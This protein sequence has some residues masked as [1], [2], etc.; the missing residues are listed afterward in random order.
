MNSEWGIPTDM[1]SPPRRPTVVTILA[2]M[3]TVGAVVSLL[4]G[5]VLVFVVFQGQPPTGNAP[6]LLAI[7]FG[8]AAVSV[9]YGACAFGLWTMRPFGWTAQ[10][11]LA[12]IGLIGIPLGTVLAIA[13]L[14]YMW[15]PGVK[16]LFSGRP[17]DDFSAAER[18]QIAA[19]YELSAA[20]IAVAVVVIGLTAVATL[21][22]VA[23]IAIP[24]L[25][26][27]RMAGNEA[28]AIGTLRAIMTGQAAFASLCGHGGYAA[29]LEDLR[30]PGSDASGAFVDLQLDAGTRNGYRFALEPTATPG[31]TAACNGA[32]PVAGYTASAAPLV[33]GTSGQRFFAIDERGVVFQSRFPIP[34]PIVESDEVRPVR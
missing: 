19:A 15:R 20:A 31:G 7:A 29:S 32:L 18:T 3:N 21:G 4:V 26:R 5:G 10:V 30:R 8:S 25:L 27:A 17:A 28:A 33:P 12:F 11:A 22:V 6:F 23:A 13:I 2:A 16:L 9:A 24:G 1:A 34:G 14:V